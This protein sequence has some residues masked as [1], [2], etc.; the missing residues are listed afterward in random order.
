MGQPEAH[1][2]FE[3]LAG[4]DSGRIAETLLPGLLHVEEAVIEGGLTL[5]EVQN[6]APAALTLTADIGKTGSSRE[7]EICPDIAVGEFIFLR[8]L[9]L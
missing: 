1:D 4:R 5:K 7:A 3:G 8:F 9:A 6:I 2:V